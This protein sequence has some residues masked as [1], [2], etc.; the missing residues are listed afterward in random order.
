M[1][2]TAN[3]LGSRHCN[4]F[5][6]AVGWQGS[7]VHAKCKD[8]S[9]RRQ[10]GDHDECDL[11]TLHVCFNDARHGFCGKFTSN[12]RSTCRNNLEWI[13]IRCSSCK[14]LDHLVDESA[15]GG[16][17]TESSAEQLKDCRLLV[18]I[19]SRKARHLQRLIAVAVDMSS[20]A[21]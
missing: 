17:N 21:A 2:G 10:G 20:G 3:Q 6:F 11:D 13:D 8:A 7:E 9:K 19:R 16:R 14:C 1:R 18:E 12:L 15:L 4:L 5:S